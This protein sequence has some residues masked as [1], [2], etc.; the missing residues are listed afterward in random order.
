MGGSGDGASRA[1]TNADLM[2][3]LATLLPQ[4]ASLVAQRPQQPGQSGGCGEGGD[5]RAT[6]AI[7]MLTAVLPQLATAMSSEFCSPSTSAAIR[8]Q[9]GAL[10]SQMRLVEPGATPNPNTAENVFQSLTPVLV[11]LL[12]LLLTFATLARGQSARLPQGASA[13]TVSALPVRTLTAMDVQALREEH[14][15]CV[16]CMTSFAEGDEQMTLPCLHKFH[17]ACVDLWL[18]SSGFCPVCR[19][20]IADNEPPSSS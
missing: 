17:S 5:A 3:A 12:P 1:S 20:S 13:T 6:M 19:H 15:A 4:L 14:N 18:H 9:L 8:T 10:I 7:D 11:G 16:I 2:P